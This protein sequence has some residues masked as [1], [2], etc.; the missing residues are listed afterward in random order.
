MG[1]H[2]STSYMVILRPFRYIKHKNQNYNRKISYWVRMRSQSAVLCNVCQSNYVD[3]IWQIACC[4]VSHTRFTFHTIKMS[5]RL[6]IFI[7]QYFLRIDANFPIPL[8]ALSEAWVY[9]RLIVG[10]CG[11]ESARGCICLSVVSVVT[12]QVE[13]SAS[14]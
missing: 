6:I 11:F 9:G 10:D 4:L 8:A 12:C 3:C 5:F 13:V 7:A 14:G 1:L 2:V